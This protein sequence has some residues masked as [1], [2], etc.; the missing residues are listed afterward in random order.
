MNG[1]GTKETF[2]PIARKYRESRAK[3]GSQHRALLGCWGVPAGGGGGGGG[4]GRS[5]GQRPDEEEEEEE[6][7]EDEDEVM[8]IEKENKD[9][10]KQ[11]LKMKMASAGT[12]WNS[13][14]LGGHPLNHPS[15]SIYK[16]KY[17]YVAVRVVVLAGGI[18]IGSVHMKRFSRICVLV[19]GLSRVPAPALAPQV[20]VR[21]THTRAAPASV[22]HLVGEE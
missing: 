14:P 3:P 7:Q 13:L 19:Y 11:M 8:V 10:A 5:D 1:Q 9:E 17:T 6:E 22:I 20:R 18:G 4:K 21:G 2:T 12:P 16:Y 15:Y